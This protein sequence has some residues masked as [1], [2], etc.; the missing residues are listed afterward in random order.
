MPHM[1]THVYD[2]PAG[3]SARFYI[4]GDYAFPMSGAGQPAYWIN[5]D[6]WYACPVAGTAC[7]VKGKYLHEYP[8]GSAKFYTAS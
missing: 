3:S 8:S 5:G 1:V 6:F 2:Y 4:N 7:W